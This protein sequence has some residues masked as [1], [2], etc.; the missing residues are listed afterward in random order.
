[1]EGTDQESEWED[2]SQ[3][4]DEVEFL[5]RCSQDVLTGIGADAVQIVA[6]KYDPVKGTIF[7]SGGI[8]NIYTRIEASRQFVRRTE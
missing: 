7:V 5:I 2:P 4:P 6:T 8:G 3:T 1:M